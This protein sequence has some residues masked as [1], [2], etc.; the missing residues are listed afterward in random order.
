MKSR[1]LGATDEVLPATHVTLRI[2][3]VILISAR[4]TPGASTRHRP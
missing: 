2:W 1:A 3:I 4:F